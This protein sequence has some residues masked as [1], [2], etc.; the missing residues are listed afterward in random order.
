MDVVV[1]MFQETKIVVNNVETYN[2][3][4]IFFVFV[5]AYISCTCTCICQR[6]R[7][8]CINMRNKVYIL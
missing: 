2:M 4:L 7:I 5:H 8:L 1:I 3:F 6:R